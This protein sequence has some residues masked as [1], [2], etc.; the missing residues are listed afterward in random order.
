MIEKLDFIVF[1]DKEFDY[2]RRPGCDDRIE[3]RLT[4]KDY[5]WMEYTFECWFP[6]IKQGDL[7]IVASY[8][9]MGSC[10][11]KITQV[12]NGEK[13][14]HSFEFSNSIWKRFITNYMKKHIDQWITGQ[15]FYAGEEAVAFYNE[16]LNDAENYNIKEVV[17]EENKRRHRLLKDIIEW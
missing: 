5:D 17:K 7:C 3:T 9:G 15:V 2:S 4:L 14:L 16:I 6:T 13:Y 10:N 12:I 8:N 1:D 11:A